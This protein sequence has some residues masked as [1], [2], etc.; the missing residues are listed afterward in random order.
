MSIASSLLAA[1]LVPLA[2]AQAAS[3]QDVVAAAPPV[4][5]M[6]PDR[7][8]LEP[9][10]R[11][12]VLP[13][14]WRSSPDLV[15]TTNGDATGFH[16]L[17]AEERTGYAWRTVASLSEPGVDTDRWIG[18]VCLTESGRKAV[19]VY[20][21]RALTNDGAL[22]QRG[23]LSAIIDIATGAVTKLPVRSTIAYFSP[24]CGAGER[25]VLTQ[26]RGGDTPAGGGAATRLIVVDASSATVVTTTE[27]RGQVTSAIPVA[28][29]I[30]AALGR[31]LIA[32]SPNGTV[33]KLA[34][35]AS[36]PFQIMADSGNGVLFMEH[37]A[38]VA[39]V[40]RL[41]SIDGRGSVGELA[42]GKL[43]EF[44]IV[45]STHGRAFITG[46]PES[47][48][49]LPA[50]V[51][52]L[53]VPAGS[54]VSSEG[55]L[56]ILDE[57]RST[58][59]QPGIGSAAPST[60]WERAMTL[61]APEDIDEPAQVQ[62]QAKI[63][64]TGKSVEFAL[65]PGVRAA[66]R[67]AE[68]ARP[69]PLA[70]ARPAAAKAPAQP[71]REASLASSPNDPVDD[72]AWCSVTRND[73]R[74]Q[75]YQPTPRQVEWAADQAVVG[76]LTMTRPADWKHSGLPAWTPQGLF[77]PI[78]LSGGGRVPV[79]VFLGIMAQESNLWQASGHALS[80]VPGNPL[81]GNYYGRDIFNDTEADDW[82]IDFSES[83]CGYGVTQLTDGMRKAG[84]TKPG[85][86]ALSPTQQRAA[87]LDYATNIAAGLR[88]LQGKWNETRAAG[89][90]HDNGDPRWLENWIFA[91]WAYNS[92]FHPDQGDGSP[93]GV[94]WANNPANPNYNPNRRFF[95][96]DPHD[97]AHPQ[98]WPYEE[99]VIGFAAY[100]IA[101]VDGPGFRPSWWVSTEQRD[102]AKPPI[103]QFCGGSNDCEPGASHV[104]NDPEVIGE[105]AGPCAHQ[106]SSGQYDLKCW[107][108]SPTSYHACSAN[109][110]GNELLR[111]DTTFAEQPDGTHNPPNCTITG[112]AS[113]SF[114]IDDV[115][116]TVPTLRSGCGH[117]WTNAGSFSLS[118]AADSLGRLAS[119]ID[120]H[121]IGAGFG[122]HL[123]FA[124]SRMIGDLGGKLKVTGKWTF[125]QPFNGWG[126]V[127]V[128]MPDTGAHTQQGRYDINLG[129][130]VIKQRYA[131]QRTMQHLWVSLG[132]MQLSGVPSISLSTET[133]DGAGRD[134]IAWDAVAIEPL[135]AKPRDFVVALGD[136]YTSGEGASEPDGGDD[137]YKE[138]DNNGDL[139]DDMGRNACH[140]SPF[141]WPR[142]AVMVDGASSIGVRADAWDDSLDFQFHACSGARTHNML[143]LHSVPAG[144]TPP[145]NAFGR[146]GTGQYGEVPQIDKGYLDAN[147][148]LVALSIGGNDARFADVIKECV[149][150]AGLFA[151][152]DATL[153]GETEHLNVTV[154]RDING[155]VRD[156]ILITL[157]QINQRAPNAKIV[158]M[159][160]PLLLENDG[161][162]VLGI[163]TG[164]GPWIRDMGQLM[165]DMM[166]QVAA[167]A[168]SE[169]IPTWFSNPIDEFA[170][171]G[172]CGNPESI[173]GIVED[174]TEGDKPKLLG[175][176]P[177]S[178]QSFHPKVSGTT[179]YADS[180]N[181][182][183]G[184]M[185]L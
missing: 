134:D 176:L 87:A 19:A 81:V 80:G 32:V 152:P 159:G 27:L 18:N 97:P 170:S 168:T 14:H 162:C 121:Q 182:T 179:L 122:G 67:I 63:I 185:G 180:M 91:V 25:A 50:S 177:P 10:Q 88:I 98:D 28:G 107:W 38:G 172:I 118:F 96:A 82:D 129:N 44:D 111:F 166:G 108:H 144:Q 90:I 56:A 11:D 128:H 171:K 72:D 124:H 54:E 113:G 132:V 148:T 156:S 41:N 12:A 103:Y 115:A 79:G 150:G 78:P 1:L 51:R 151:C 109:I 64:D 70:A 9:R 57:P 74:S 142:K 85:E 68:G 73:A 173:H 20:A 149:Y 49:R 155:R 30:V 116:D 130:G 137:Y 76:A 24:G 164:E 133:W 165:A 35:A 6:V 104:P 55:D 114:V 43:S 99:K 47:V 52:R 135:P 175:L 37:A 119:K 26:Q 174:T 69:H 4:R 136:S 5:Q 157:R 140:R 126:R 62:L 3:P 84:F 184:Q 100:S 178:A 29:R 86:V 7:S 167:Q 53:A 2:Q 161:Q 16:L 42:D 153:S 143:P 146:T 120:F 77:P 123:W 36:T 101:T 8:A 40:Q 22:F 117:P 83:D 17:V 21:P 147:T 131:L 60:A 106:N 65:T 145:A 15:W 183:L 23:A 125:N 110:C 127:L 75:V 48:G 45:P 71:N 92:G 46:R 139:D 13:K 58:T 158:L 95:A 33:S 141:A 39:Y 154:P 138:T 66:Q 31:H 181:Q 93:W 94:G 102:L 160:Y 112:L 61:A 89:L 163:G 59:G 34:S 105:P 169:G